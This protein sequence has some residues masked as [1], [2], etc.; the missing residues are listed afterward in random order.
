MIRPHRWLGALTVIYVCDLSSVDFVS[1]FGRNP[2]E[3][4]IVIS[5][6]LFLSFRLCTRYT[7]LH[8][9]SARRYNWHN[10]Q[11]TV[12]IKIVLWNFFNFNLDLS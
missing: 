6:R 11:Y 2:R 1:L 9:P 5:T 8:S 12:K 7:V 3:S 10:Y 4:A